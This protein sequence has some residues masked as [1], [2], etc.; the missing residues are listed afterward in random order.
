MN[1][2]NLNALNFAICAYIEMKK[3]QR[4]IYRKIDF[5]F[6]VFEYINAEKHFMMWYISSKKICS[7][8]NSKTMNWKIKNEIVENIE[9]KNQKRQIKIFQLMILK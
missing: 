4:K 6:A 9:M 5:K 2:K 8:K 3:N 7:I 1:I